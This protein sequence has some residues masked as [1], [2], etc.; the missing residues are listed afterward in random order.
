MIGL[1]ASVADIASTIASVQYPEVLQG[2][3]GVR[4]VRGVVRMHLRLA[5]TQ[6]GTGK[7]LRDSESRS[8]AEVRHLDFGFELGSSFGTTQEEETELLVAVAVLERREPE[9]ER[10]R[11]PGPGPEPEPEPALEP[12]SASVCAFALVVVRRFAFEADWVLGPDE[13]IATVPCCKVAA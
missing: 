8:K 12:V 10:E 1:V 2:C 5:G 9:R 4:A 3:C 6:A 11:E 13:A 7:N